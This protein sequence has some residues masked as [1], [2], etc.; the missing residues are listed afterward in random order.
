MNFAGVEIIVITRSSSCLFTVS[1]K[2]LTF[3]ALKIPNWEQSSERN[4][5]ITVSK[6]LE[7]IDFNKF[8][9]IQ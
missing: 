8:N 1:K 6:K 9:L 7:L 3:Q 5:V 2:L 4:L